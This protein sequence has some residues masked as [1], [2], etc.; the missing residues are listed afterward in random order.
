MTTSPSTPMSAM[1][2]GSQPC[3]C[4]VT[5][6]S[7]RW[8]RRAF[9]KA[10]APTP[11]NGRS[12]KTRNASRQYLPRD[13]DA[14]NTL[15][16]PSCG[17]T[18]VSLVSSSMRSPIPRSLKATEVKAPSGA[19]HAT[20][21]AAT[22]TRLRSRA[23]GSRRSTTIST[24]APTSTRRTTSSSTSAPKSPATASF[25]DRGCR[26]FENAS[27]ESAQAPTADPATSGSTSTGRLRRRSGTSA[28]QAIAPTAAAAAAPR[29]CVSR[30]ATTHTPMAG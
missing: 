15:P 19:R 22:P 4:C 1:V 11:S 6:E 10:P 5:D 25:A 21:T 30:I 23:D 8:R 16:P 12:S 14:A 13:D 24:A 20:A 7:V 17:A 18:F 28:N 2:W 26:L 9:S 3:A 27:L 29:D